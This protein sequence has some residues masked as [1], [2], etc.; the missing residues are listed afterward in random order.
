[1]PHPLRGGEA[2][3]R[4]LFSRVHCAQRLFAL[5]LKEDRVQNLCRELGSGDPSPVTCGVWNPFR[6]GSTLAS[7]HL[8]I[9]LED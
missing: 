7:V 4:A 6:L 9:D 3:M 5:K 8:G 1:M 2:R